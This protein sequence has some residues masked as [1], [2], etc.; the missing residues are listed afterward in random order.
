MKKC[1]DVMRAYSDIQAAYA[2]RL[3]KDDGVKEFQCNV[4]LDGLE[5]GE[6]TS[7]FLCV[8]ADG[9]FMVRECVERKFLMKPRTVKLLDASRD[10]W[11]RHGVKD[12]G[13]VI[14]AE[15]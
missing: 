6:Y 15:K 3:E 8:K 14:D 1:K 12:W 5:E 13:L 4:L 7:D 9:D 11:L 2:E 10:Y